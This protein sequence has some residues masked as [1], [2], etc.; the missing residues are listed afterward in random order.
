MIENQSR[1]V[2]VEGGEV[3][4]LIEGDVKG[5]PIVLLHG[6]SFDAETWKQIGTTAALAQA[7]HMVYAVD[8]PGYGKSSPAP[9]TTRH[10][11]RALLDSLKI[12]KP[13]VVSPPMSGRFSLPL[14]TEEP[15]RVAGFVAVA[16]VGITDL[17]DRLGNITAPV[18]PIWGEHDNLIP[19]EQADLLVRSVKRGRKVVISGGSHA[20]YMSDPAA[21]NAELLEFLG[22]LP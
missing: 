5:R 10:W 20:P 22:E 7:G 18:L 21:F 15:E 16:H 6:F 8:L 11:L 13:V 19:Q 3:H 9:G 1:W 14:V 17:K 4:Y 12:E 2:E